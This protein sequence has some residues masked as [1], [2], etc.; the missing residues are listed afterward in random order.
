MKWIEAVQNERRKAFMLLNCTSFKRDGTNDETRN[1]RRLDRLTRHTPCAVAAFRRRM[2]MYSVL[3]GATDDHCFT[4]KG[5]RE[6]EKNT[7]GQM[8]TS[9]TIE[10]RKNP[11]VPAVLVETIIHTTN[12]TDTETLIGFIFVVCR[13]TWDEKKSF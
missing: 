4:T 3:P 7:S 11:H 2:R 8:L 12:R 6:A 9:A 13:S 10:T 5:K 1:E